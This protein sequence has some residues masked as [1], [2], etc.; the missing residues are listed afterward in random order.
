MIEAHEMIV[1]NTCMQLAGKPN[2]FDVMV[3]SAAGMGCCYMRGFRVYEPCSLNPE[4]TR[5]GDP[6]TNSLRVH[7]HAFRLCSIVQ[8]RKIMR[9][10]S[11][12]PTCSRLSRWLNDQIC[13][14]CSLIAPNFP[15]PPR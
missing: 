11:S 3:R 4:P 13:K 2:Q 14:K 9:H 7:G 12:A 5:T 10:L 8:V 6:A 15:G 1:D